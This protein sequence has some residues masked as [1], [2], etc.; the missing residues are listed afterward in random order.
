MTAKRGVRT[1]QFD[2]TIKCAPATHPNLSFF[3]RKIVSIP[4]E[5][6]ESIAGLLDRYGCG[7]DASLIL[8]MDI[9]GDEWP[10][11]EQVERKHLQSFAQIICEFH[12]F[13]NAADQDWY[14]RA[15]RVIEKLVADFAVVHVHGNNAEP[16]VSIEN[17]PFPRILEV[18]FANR[19]RY[20]FLA[21]EE[22]FP[23]PLDQPNIPNRP[24]LFLGRFLF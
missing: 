16:L 11:L 2:H 15:K 23:T 19:A 3:P 13:N 1:Y 6:G 5:G 24:D 21:S 17:V 7:A 22:T 10:I 9:E 12:G 18:T 20:K 8:K 14:S 4:G